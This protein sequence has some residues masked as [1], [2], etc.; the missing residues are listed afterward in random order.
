MEEE[1]V[2]EIT[3]NMPAEEVI[4]EFIG[5]A[6]IK[7][8]VIDDLSAS[9]ISVLRD[10][11]FVSYFEAALQRVLDMKKYDVRMIKTDGFFWVR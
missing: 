7:K 4:G 9:T 11:L 10:K 8:N 3:K 1:R 5:I 6:K 2:V